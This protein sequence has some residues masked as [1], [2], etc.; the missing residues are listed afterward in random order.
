MASINRE[1]NG[2]RTIQF[3]GSDGKR[4]SIRLGKV[5]QRMAEAVKVLVEHLTAAQFSGGALE[6]ETARKVAEL[7]DALYKRLAAVGLL[8]SREA[9]TVVSVAGFLKD[10]VARRVDVKPA[11]QRSMVAGGGEPPGLLRGKPRLADD[12]RSGGRGLQAV[13]AESQAGP[14]HGCQAAAI[15][16]TILPGGREAE[17]DRRLTRL[18][19]WRAKRRPARIGS[20]SSRG[21]ISTGCWKPAPMSTGG[22]SSRLC[23]FGGLRCPSEVLSSEVAG[24]ELGAGP[25]PR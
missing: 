13:P 19:T 20:N 25:H 7:D 18:P 22:L 6:P 2:R 4:R 1:S 8:K 21:S 17:A 11:T 15:R 16:A 5:P 9:A 23:R 3:V 10:Y 24:R 14:D 12:R